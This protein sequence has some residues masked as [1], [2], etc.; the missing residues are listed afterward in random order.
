MNPAK[1][2]EQRPIRGDRTQSRLPGVHVGIHQ[3]RDHDEGATVNYFRVRRMDAGANGSDPLVF[4]QNAA[5]SQISPLGIH[6]D[7]G[8]IVDEESAHQV[9]MLMA[10]RK[11]NSASFTIDKA[12]SPQERSTTNA[13]QFWEMCLA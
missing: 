13:C 1:V 9:I 4:D 5:R 10:S 3:A 12:F 7:D 11:S 6:R 2:F 8:G